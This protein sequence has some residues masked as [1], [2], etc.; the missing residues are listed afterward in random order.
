M[1]LTLHVRARRIRRRTT[2]TRQ[3]TERLRRTH[4]HIRR[5]ITQ[6]V[7]RHRG[8]LLTHILTQTLHLLRARRL[9]IKK[10]TR[11]TARTQRHAHRRI[12]QRIRTRR[13]LKR[14]ATNIK[15]KDAARTP[16]L[17]AAHR[18]VRNCRLLITR[19][20]VQA[21]TGLLTHLMQHRRTITRLTDSARGERQQVLRLIL[22]GEVAGASHEA[23]Q[24]V[25]ALLRNTALSVEVLH[26]LQR[27]LV[28]RVR[29]GARSRA[30]VNQ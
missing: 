3:R 22:D 7:L 11:Q 2:N 19:N 9:L 21:H 23:G 13:K 25:R 12:R 4:R 17:P 6:Q 10:L 14:A 27:N 8:N 30:A 16:A 1:H 26:E 24:R 15:I 18:K 28:R 5:T 29:F 20:T